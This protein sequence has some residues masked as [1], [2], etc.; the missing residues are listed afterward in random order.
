MMHN[1]AILPSRKTAE[2]IDNHTRSVHLPDHIEPSWQEGV[3]RIATGNGGTA[4]SSDRDREDTGNEQPEAAEDGEPSRWT[5]RLPA[6]D[7]NATST[8]PTAPPVDIDDRDAGIHHADPPDVIELPDHAEP[9][10]PVA[11]DGDFP[12][13]HP[14][15]ATEA[16]PDAATVELQDAWQS[17]TYIDPETADLP[18]E[19]DADTSGKDLTGEPGAD[20]SRTVVTDVSHTSSATNGSG[21]AT[22]AAR[23]VTFKAERDTH[24]AADDPHIRET[25]IDERPREERGGPS[26]AIGR[27]GTGPLQQFIEPFL[28]LRWTTFQR[29]V[30]LGGSLLIL[31]ALLASSAGLAL[32]IASSIVSILIVLS[33]TRQD[34][35][36]HE[37]AAQLTG[38]G[39]IGGIIGIIIGTL[40]SWLTSSSWFD[41][42]RLN[43]GAAGFGGRFADA[44]GSAPFTVWFLNGLIFPLIALAA[45]A[46]APVALRRMPQFRNEVMDGVILVGASAAG[47]N[48]GTTLVFWAPMLGDRGP[49]TSVGDW[50]LTTIGVALLRPVVITLAGA[51]LGAGIWRYMDSPK[52]STLILP[53]AGSI[54][55]YLLLVLGSIQLG[56]AGLWPETI[57]TLLVTAGTF[58]IYRT[59][60]KGAIASDQ[61][62]LG[63]NR[64]RTVCP[65][66]GQLTPPG[67]FCANCGKALPKAT[68][69]DDAGSAPSSPQAGE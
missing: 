46:V 67:T 32:I 2:A 30:L 17:D 18:L 45:I 6:I 47:F 39:L 56:P 44:A 69:T 9:S 38:I 31:L 5:E 61:S 4:M 63:E 8:N 26:G 57:W 25:V 59:V 55:A 20:T 12:E 37:S 34:V 48:I 64:T 14:E 42:G 68:S 13:F 1:V 40:G 28:H 22:S 66:C 16:S 10:E 33:L 41:S 65:N 49:Q 7:P 54:G 36:E 62:M 60:L 29:L 24:A 53:A 15:E 43:Y 11:P 27:L 35:F 52:L 51:M 19:P 23:T 3:L 21:D 58:A 50:T